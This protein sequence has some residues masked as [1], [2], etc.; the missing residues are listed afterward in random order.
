[1]DEDGRAQVRT[2]WTFTVPPGQVWTA[3]TEAQHVPRWFDTLDPVPRAV[4]DRYRLVDSATEGTVR[5]C[6]PGSLLALSWEY[7]TDTSEVEVRLTAPTNAAGM[8]DTA[9]AGAAA[10][11]LEL[12]HTMT[13]DDHWR[14]YG[15]GATGVGWDGALLA[16]ERYLRGE[17]GTDPASMTAYF[18]T[19]EGHAWIESCARM[20]EAAHRAAGASR[21][22]AAACRDR[23]VAAYTA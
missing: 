15:P 17:D 7:G 11:R 13:A 6:A 10:C 19:A 2:A 23:T 14:E 21:E 18:A 12:L 3:L 5:A 8:T 4:G 1:M 22:R 9:G 16:L 20:W